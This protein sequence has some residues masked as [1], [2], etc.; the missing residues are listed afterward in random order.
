MTEEREVFENVFQ[1]CGIGQRGPCEVPEVRGCGA[2]DDAGVPEMR[3]A[4]RCGGS[5]YAFGSRCA[6]GSEGPR[7]AG[8]A[9]RPLAR[10]AAGLCVAE[11]V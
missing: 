8:G 4:R 5:W 11:P 6:R 9:G 2:S 10:R 7:R 1:T 3:R